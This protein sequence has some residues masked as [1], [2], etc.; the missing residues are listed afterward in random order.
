M[1]YS[2]LLKNIIEES[3]YSFKEVSDK[4]KELGKSIDP[5]YISKL[6]NNK[7]SPPKDDISWAIAKV[8]NT[9]EDMLV[10][11]G[12]LDK[13]PSEIIDFINNIRTDLIENKI[14]DIATMIPE[15]ELADYKD[16]LYNMPL[17]QFVLE[18]NNE[19]NMKIDISD[20]LEIDNIPVEDNS[21]APF[22]IKGSIV[23]YEK[24]SEYKNE[25]IVVFYYNNNVLIRKYF[26]KDE[27]LL[28]YSYNLEFEPIITL[29]NQVSII[30]KVNK[31]V[32]YK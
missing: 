9:N 13:A 19:S 17:S 12:Y 2:E 8:C 24:L 11:E 7:I 3:G 18:I 27:F 25:D 28:F 4:C 10:L 31:I 20:V 32:T 23:Y 21:M 15:D 6:V 29:P 26:K 1:G 14:T 30:G 16:S 22:I 5:S